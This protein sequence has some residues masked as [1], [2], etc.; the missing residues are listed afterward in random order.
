[1]SAPLTDERIEEI[2]AIRPSIVLNDASV[3]ELHA[4]A[5]ELRS[6]RAE[7]AR[8]RGECEQIKA[9][10]VLAL[11]LDQEQMDAD[12]KERAGLLAAVQRESAAVNEAN[13]LRAHLVGVLHEISRCTTLDNAKTFAKSALADLAERDAGLWSPGPS[14][15]AADWKPGH[16]REVPDAQADSLRAQLATAIAR[17]EQAERL[18]SQTIADGRVIESQTAERIA[19]WLEDADCDEVGIDTI[20][21]MI[22]NSAWRKDNER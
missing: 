5:A 16:H 1:M 12:A 11:A 6:S 7:L 3:R 13:G 20:A 17:A 9:D 4:M 22:R 14:D 2:L 10:A 21:G 19:A 8:L 15:D 18:L